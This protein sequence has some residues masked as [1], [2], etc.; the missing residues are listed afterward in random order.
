LT[1]SGYWILYIQYPATIRIRHRAGDIHVARKPAPRL[2]RRHSCR[3]QSALPDV[4]RKLD[5]WE[6]TAAL[7]IF[8]MDAYRFFVDL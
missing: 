5:V 3:L 1:V 7:V 8:R 2:E 6:I 4:V